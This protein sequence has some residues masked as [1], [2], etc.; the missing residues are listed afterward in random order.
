[1]AVR[2]PQTYIDDLTVAAGIEEARG[3]E[4]GTGQVRYHVAA[5]DEAAW[6]RLAWTRRLARR[7]PAAPR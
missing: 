1:M 2:D 3:I 4:G 5:V 7:P 6:T